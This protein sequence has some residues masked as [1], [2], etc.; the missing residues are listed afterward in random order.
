MASMNS[1]KD[2]ECVLVEYRNR[3]SFLEEILNFKI[4]I[5]IL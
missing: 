4:E 2:L 5:N 3:H 1:P